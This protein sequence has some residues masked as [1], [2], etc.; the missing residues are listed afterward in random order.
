[1][2]LSNKILILTEK[3]FDFKTMGPGEDE[4][5]PV[6]QCNGFKDDCEYIWD[7]YYEN[8]VDRDNFNNGIPI[9]M[10][11]CDK[12][13]GRFVIDPFSEPTPITKKEAKELFPEISDDIINN[14][15]FDLFAVDLAYILRITTHTMS[16]LR[17]KDENA[18]ISEE[19]IRDLYNHIS[20]ECPYLPKDEILEKYGLEKKKEKRQNGKQLS[21][22]VNSYNSESPSPNNPYPEHIDLN[23][24]GVDIKLLCRSTT[25]T[26]FHIWYSGC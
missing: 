3:G 24:D 6:C 4:L 13:H 1:M 10:I 25:G 12:C 22:P 9:G 2:E 11:W 26:E 16:K 20:D 18:T 7:D 17:L 23:H 14:E 19:A 15:G 8:D 21:L 5:V